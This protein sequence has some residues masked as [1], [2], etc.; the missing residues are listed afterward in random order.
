VRPGTLTGCVDK[1]RERSRRSQTSKSSVWPCGPQLPPSAASRKMPDPFR[2]ATLAL[3][4]A[5]RRIHE[6]S[7]VVQK[8]IS[9][10][11]RCRPSRLLARPAQPG[12]QEAVER[13]GV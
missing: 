11:S 2:K 12:E 10:S 13:V 1:D 3:C 6:N 9:T 4:C 5:Y 8:S 7:S